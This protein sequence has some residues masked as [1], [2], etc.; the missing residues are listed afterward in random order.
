MIKKLNI[1]NEKQLKL[2]MNSLNEKYREETNENKY[3]KLED[4]PYGPYLYNKM[5][6]IE[7][8]F[9]SIPYEKIIETLEQ[10]KKYSVLNISISS[11][12]RVEIE[13]E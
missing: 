7:P 8:Q 6:E 5:C 10:N 2:L 13:T 9:S 4:V 12:D 11:P 1:T 3:T